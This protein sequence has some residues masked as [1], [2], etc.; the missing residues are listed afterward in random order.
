MQRRTTRRERT[1]AG[2]TLLE[3]LIALTV[4]AFGLLGLAAMQIYSL[5]TGR[6]SKHLMQA[7]M[8]AQDRMETVQYLPWGS[9]PP[10]GGWTTL[11]PVTIQVDANSGTLNEITFGLEQRVANVVVGQTRNVDV[12]VTWTEP[13]DPNPNKALVVSTVRFNY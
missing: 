5:Q 11:T 3:V 9:V 10:T 7:T 13:E 4:L 2:F 12:R 1:R 8:V 6:E